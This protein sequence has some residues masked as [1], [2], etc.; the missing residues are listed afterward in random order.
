M[1]K[2]C[3][4]PPLARPSQLIFEIN[5][6]AGAAAQKLLEDQQ[7]HIIRHAM[8]WGQAAAMQLYFAF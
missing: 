5:L 2:S 7:E 3:V 1:G 6:F 4:S 8:D